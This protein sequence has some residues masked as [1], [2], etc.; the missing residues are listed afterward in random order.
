M[1]E[2]VANLKPAGPAPTHEV[3]WRK[4]LAADEESVSVTRLAAARLTH[5]APSIL[6]TTRQGVLFALAPDGN[7]LWSKDFGTPLNDVTAADL[8]GDGVDEIVLGRQ[9]HRVTVM[10]AAGGERWSQ[11]LEHYRK[12]PYVNVVRTGD[13]DGDGRPEVIA[14]GENWRF[15]AFTSDGTELW[16]F[17]SVHPSRSGAVDDL[18]GDGKAEV[19][20]GTHYYWMTALTPEGT[21]RWKYNFGPICYDIATGS[22]DGDGTRGV[23]CGGG[24]GYIHY[25][26]A[27]GKARMKYNTGDEVRHVATCDLDGDGKDEILA[28][29]LSHSV[30]C[31]GPDGARLWRTDLGAPLSAL[32]AGVAKDGTPQVFAGTTDGTLADFSPNG[33]ILR[34]TDLGGGVDDILLLEDRGIA[35]TT[36]GELA[37][38][39]F[40]K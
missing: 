40:L 10:D 27:N 39:A 7:V 6:A 9:D 18:D 29:S 11:T 1:R 24:G 8:D 35:A 5:G 12:P 28:G 36:N 4:P 2:P 31:F 33:A 20:C 14:G 13:L 34:A 26:D 38:V 16:H 22:F 23:V 30:Y 21:Q 3:L 19:L 37:A 17:E 15:Y 32:A 25:V